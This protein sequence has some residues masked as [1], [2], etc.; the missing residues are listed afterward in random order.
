MD[1]VM[2]DKGFDIKEALKEH[3]GVLNLPPHRK[4]EQP[5][6]TEEEVK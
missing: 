5:Q 6:F 4:P 1:H 3:G 2:A